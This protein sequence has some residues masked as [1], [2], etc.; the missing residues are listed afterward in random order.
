MTMPNSEE[1]FHHTL[2]DRKTAFDILPPS[3]KT[4]DIFREWFNK[5]D[6][7]HYNNEQTI[8]RMINNPAPLTDEEQSKLRLDEKMRIDAL[9]GIQYEFKESKKID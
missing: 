1:L 8:E 9:N 5:R 6:N 3:N 7:A 2:I 4:I